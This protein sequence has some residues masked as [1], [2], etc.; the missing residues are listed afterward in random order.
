MRLFCIALLICRTILQ[1]AHPQ[2][3]S[4]A[5]DRLQVQEGTLLTHASV[6]FKSLG[7]S[8]I[9]V[10]EMEGNKSQKKSLPVQYYSGRLPGVLLEQSCAKQSLPKKQNKT[11]RTHPKYG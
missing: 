4:L 7:T 2:G 9:T 6:G 8:R 11:H 3:I 10:F 5:T 1:R